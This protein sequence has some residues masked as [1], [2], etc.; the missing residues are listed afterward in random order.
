HRHE[1]RQILDNVELR[2]APWMSRHAQ[3]VHRHEDRICTDECYPEVQLAK[4]FI[5]HAAEHLRHPVI[6]P[7]E[8]AEDPSHTHDEM[9]VADNEICVVEINVE[10]W[11]REERTA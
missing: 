10:C 5:H 3:V 1:W 9:E 8:H 6:G 2:I 7:G 4:P 11:L